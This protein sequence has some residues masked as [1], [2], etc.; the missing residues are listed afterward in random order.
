MGWVGEG[1]RVR[2]VGVG[3]GY[4]WFFACNFNETN[5]NTMTNANITKSLI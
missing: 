5:F 2:K 3:D 4:I 1:E